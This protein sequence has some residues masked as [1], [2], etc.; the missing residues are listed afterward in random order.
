[1]EILKAF[2]IIIKCD[3]VNIQSVLEDQIPDTGQSLC[4]GTGL[5]GRP[6]SVVS[7]GL[8]GSPVNDVTDNRYSSKISKIVVSRFKKRCWV[9]RSET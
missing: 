8:Q 2:K 4:A 9:S 5:C 1:M 6:W 3:V 7:R